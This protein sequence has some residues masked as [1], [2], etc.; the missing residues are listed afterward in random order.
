MLHL[1][2]QQGAGL[3]RGI[4]AGCRDGLLLRGPRVAAVARGVEHML[5]VLTYFERTTQRQA[6][7]AAAPH[8]A[9]RDAGAQQNAGSRINL[10]LCSKTRTARAVFVGHPRRAAG[11]VRNG[12]TLNA[13]TLRR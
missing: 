11:R 7:G 8:A 12:W 5:F 1:E 10:R 6:L 13:K 4:L 3:A 9:S 2:L